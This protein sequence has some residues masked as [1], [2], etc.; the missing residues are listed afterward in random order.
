MLANNALAGSQCRRQNEISCKNFTSF[1]NNPFTDIPF[2]IPP[3][4][5]S[6]GFNLN[7]TLKNLG[8]TDAFTP[9]VANFSGMDGIDNGIPWIDLVAHESYIWINE[10]G[11]FAFAGT[12]MVLT[13]GMH[14]SFN[15]TR[16]FVFIIRDIPTG[17]I[18]FMGRVLDP[19]VE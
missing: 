12:G 6:S 9:G 17:T 19:S 4:K 11:T 18:L 3:F 7:N 16:P 5:F 15:A 10:Y 13:Y 2:R 8:L 1:Y 14:D